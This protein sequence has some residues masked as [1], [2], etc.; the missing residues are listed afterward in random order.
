[1]WTA[2]PICRMLLTQLERLAVSRAC[3]IAGS[4]M[5]INRPIM[6][7]TT[8]NS[9]SV[10]PPAAADRVQRRICGASVV[11]RATASFS[12]VRRWPPYLLR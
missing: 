9:T 8:S 4:S 11:P 12:R 2:V 10:K 7:I 6:A 3:W 1:M 5:A